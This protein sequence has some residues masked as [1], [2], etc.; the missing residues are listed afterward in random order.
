MSSCKWVNVK[1]I[2]LVNWLNSNVHNTIGL[3][4][5]DQPG[6]GRLYNPRFDSPIPAQTYQE[7]SWI[8]QTKLNKI[9]SEPKIRIINIIGSFF[10][11]SNVNPKGNNKNGIIKIT[12]RADQPTK[13]C[14]ELVLRKEK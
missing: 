11:L 2:E 10:L 14:Q 7:T 13:P 5:P 1:K 3:I 9:P 12:Y 4:L 8:N 6:A